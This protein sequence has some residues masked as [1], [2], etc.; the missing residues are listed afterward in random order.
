MLDAG[1]ALGSIAISA[2]RL[3]WKFSV[4]PNM[5]TEIIEKLV[6]ISDSNKFL[7]KSEWERGLIFGVVNTHGI[8][9]REGVDVSNISIIT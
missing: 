9:L 1:H 8:P 2:A 3:G 5:D 7:E 6:G 4:L